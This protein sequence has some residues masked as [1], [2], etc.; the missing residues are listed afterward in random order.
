MG[1]GSLIYSKVVCSHIRVQVSKRI[2]S[3]SGPKNQVKEGKRDV[4]R[5]SLC[6]SLSVIHCI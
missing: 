4:K 5:R 1:Y 2:P 6:K 3:N